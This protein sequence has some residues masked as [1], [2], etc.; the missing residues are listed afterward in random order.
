MKCW[1]FEQVLLKMKRIIYFIIFLAGIYSCS[2]RGR[3]VEATENEVPAAARFAEFGEKQLSLIGDIQPFKSEIRIDTIDES[4]YLIN[5][6]LYTDFPS[7][8]PKFDFQIKYPKNSVSILWSSRSWS[9]SSYIN[10]PNYSRLQS[11]Y[12]VVSALTNDDKNR[13]TMASWDDFKN[14]F[15]GIDI[16]KDFDSLVFVFNFFNTSVPDAEVLEYKAQILIDLQ[17]KQFSKSIRECIQWRLD[18]EDHST[19]RKI[20]MS[21]LPVYSL[22]YPMNRNI[23]IENI[24]YY[25]DS[26]SS[27]GFKSVLFDDGWQDVV[28]FDIDTNGYWDPSQ[29]NVVKEFMNKAHEKDMK[30]ALWYTKPFTGAHKYVFKK[31]EGKYL[32]YITSSQPVLDIRYPDVRKYLSKLYSNVVTEWGVDGIWFDFLNGYYPDEHIIVTEDN[33]RDFVSVRKSL[34][35]L[36]LEMEGDLITSNPDLSIN[37]SYPSVGPLHTSNL[38]TINGFLGTTVLNDVREKLVNNRLMYGEYSPFIEVMGIHPRDPA[39]EVALKF[40]SVMFGAPYISYFSYTLPEEIRKTLGFWIQYWQSN[41]ELLLQGDFEAFDPVH[42][43]T[44]LKSANESKQII[45]VYGRTAPVDLG[46]FQFEIADI[47]NSC[48]YQFVSVTGTPTGKVD[49]ITYDHTGKYVERGSLKFKRGI[50]TVE[51]PVAGYTHLIVK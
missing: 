50:A 19:I 31:Y 7:A 30:V 29:T 25:F 34:D 33:G 36:R 48:E 8:L 27:M 43:Y 51:V 20:D 41:N 46:Y 2:P 16:K 3:I 32:Q 28:R 1:D 23:P 6:I 24:T 9:N 5:L 12:N 11:D 45:G 18:K 21:L 47:I 44:V 38:K 39:V 4:K 17:E 26:I 42:R 22:W 37:Q 13:L 14:R 15:T 10:I 40:Q 35:S 49:Y